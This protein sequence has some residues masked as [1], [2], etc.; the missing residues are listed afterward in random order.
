MDVTDYVVVD[1]RELESHVGG[2]VTRRVDGGEEGLRAGF[3]VVRATYSPPF[4]ETSGCRRVQA[5][6]FMKQSVSLLP[7]GPARR[8][9]RPRCPLHGR[10]PRGSAVYVCIAVGIL[11]RRTAEAEPGGVV[12]ATSPGQPVSV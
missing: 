12:P 5:A 7:D 3:G 6:H 2:G 1:Q 4:P 10:Q 8:R 11:R 9:N